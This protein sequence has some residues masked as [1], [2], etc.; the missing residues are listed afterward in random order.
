MS[1][2]LQ[3]FPLHLEFMKSMLKFK[4]FVGVSEPYIILVK[5]VRVPEYTVNRTSILLSDFMITTPIDEK[6]LQ[7]IKVHRTHI[8]I[9]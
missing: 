2:F 5:T 6:I 7:K 1:R 8:N 4:S 3:V 9:F